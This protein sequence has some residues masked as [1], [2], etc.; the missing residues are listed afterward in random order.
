MP[1]HEPLLDP[2]IADAEP[3]RR[4]GPWKLIALVAAVTLVA[5]WLVPVDQDGEPTPAVTGTGSDTAPSLLAPQPQ[6][7]GTAEPLALPDDPSV[8]LEA[9][10]AGPRVGRPGSR[11]RSLI[12]AMRASGSVD[13]AEIHSKAAEAQ[14]QGEYADAYLLYFFAAREGH[15]E[16]ALA[17]GRQA[18]PA[19][20]D[21]NDSVFS[22]ADYQQAH[23]WLQR[24]AEAGSSEAAERLADLRGRLEGLAAGGDPQAQRITL[25]WQ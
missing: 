6:T 18:D 22:A 20:R 24:A 19:S 17:L 23:K 9:T 12:A 8:E 3:Q 25:L 15:A 4:A 5:V 10:A 11:A 21:P 2:E 14:A 13:L 1:T 16:S 7:A